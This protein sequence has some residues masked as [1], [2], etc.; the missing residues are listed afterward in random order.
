MSRVFLRPGNNSESQLPRTL[1]LLLSETAG[2]I[3]VTR[4]V[5]VQGLASLDLVRTQAANA[6]NKTVVQVSQ[7]IRGELIATK[8][9]SEISAP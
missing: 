7:D 9:Y 6:V 4:G 2:G 5:V 1:K 3:L 8:G